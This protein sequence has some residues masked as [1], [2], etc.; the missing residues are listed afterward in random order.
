VS[1]ARRTPWGWHSLTA[2]WAERIVASANVP[3]GSLILDIGAGKGALTA[4]LVAAGAR[5]IAVEF[6][7]ERAAFLRARFADDSVTV[8]QAD[9]ADLRLP[10]CPFSVVSNPPFAIT[11]PLL[12]RLLHPGSRLQSAHLVLQRDAAQRWAAGDVKGAAKWLRQF[13]I[14][15]DRRLPRSAFH[16]RPNVDTVVLAIHRRA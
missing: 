16:P 3:A 15:I 8:V 13:D 1:G 4:P 9:A 14:R 2:D 10:R 6:H 7:A 5:V 12:T 11:T